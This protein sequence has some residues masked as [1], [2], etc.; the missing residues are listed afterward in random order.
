MQVKIC[1]NLDESSSNYV[2]QCGPDIMGWI[3]SH[4]SKRQITIASALH[5]INNIKQTNPHI[6]HWGVFAHNSIEEIV[7][8]ASKI[9]TLDA[10]QIVESPIFIEKLIENLQKQIQIIPSIRVAEKL[11]PVILEPYQNFNCC[12]VDAFVAN[13]PGGTGK[14]INP[15]FLDGM[16]IPYFLAGGLNE[17]NVCD[18]VK[19]LKIKPLGVD[20]SSGVEKDGL[21]GTKDPQKVRKF[22]DSVRTMKK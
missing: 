7:E 21:P 17:Q 14:K 16:N 6:A 22:I 1:G 9:E 12:I 11:T 5:Q 8:T 18:S 19:V 10:I 3:F 2:A 13:Q 15:D 4:K 20:V